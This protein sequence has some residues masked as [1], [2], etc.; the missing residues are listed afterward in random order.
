MKEYNWKIQWGKEKGENKIT[1]LTV[2]YLT[3]ES[4]KLPFKRKWYRLK[5]NSKKLSKKK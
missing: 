4:Q 3:G 2:T 5:L 1:S